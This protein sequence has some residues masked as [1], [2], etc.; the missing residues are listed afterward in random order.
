MQMFDQY[1]INNTIFIPFRKVIVLARKYRQID[2][3]TDRWGGGEGYQE[4]EQELTSGTEAR[5]LA[6]ERAFLSSCCGVVCLAVSVIEH[7]RRE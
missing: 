6:S 5:Q 3:Q 4:L 7:P 1:R 2:R